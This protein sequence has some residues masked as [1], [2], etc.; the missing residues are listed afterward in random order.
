MTRLD[1]N[2][3]ID[4]SLL[5]LA[6]AEHVTPRTAIPTV[7]RWGAPAFQ[8]TADV[9]AGRLW[10]LVRLDFIRIDGDMRQGTLRPTEAGQGHAACLLARQE[11]GDCAPVH[12]SQ[13]LRL[14]LSAALP[15]P[16]AI[17]GNG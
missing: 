8:P 14:A 11:R 9:V 5:L 6:R 1:P 4:L 2:D 12:L 13:A 3:L 17:S 16:A 10:E 15:N 7:Q